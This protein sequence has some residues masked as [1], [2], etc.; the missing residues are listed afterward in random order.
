MK[1]YIKKFITKNKLSGVK[2]L[3]LVISY[4]NK[5]FSTI[6]KS[7]LSFIFIGFKSFIQFP[8]TYLNHNIF[9]YKK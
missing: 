4:F 9:I 8:Q 3:L 5:H 7:F 2:K 6:K 1:K